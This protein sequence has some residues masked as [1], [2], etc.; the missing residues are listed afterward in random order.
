[1][2]KGYILYFKE[3]FIFFEFTLEL[4]GKKYTKTLL[5]EIKN[6]AINFP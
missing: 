1:M 2:R 3:F 4:H 6:I 5:C